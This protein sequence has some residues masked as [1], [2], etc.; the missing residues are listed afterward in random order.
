LIEE[1]MFTPEGAR[2]FGN[3]IVTPGEGKLLLWQRPESP[4]PLGR[5]FNPWSNPHWQ[6]SALR[7]ES[8]GWYLHLEDTTPTH[9]CEHD[10]ALDLVRYRVPRG[11]VTLRYR[12]TH[13]SAH[14]ETV[15]EVDDI[16]EN[17]PSEKARFVLVDG[18]LDIGHRD[19]QPRKAQFRSGIVPPGSQF[20]QL[21]VIGGG[22]PLKPDGQWQ[23]RVIDLNAAC[24]RSGRY[25]FHRALFMRLVGSLDIKSLRLHTC[26]IPVPKRTT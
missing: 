12:T 20:A 17:D 11:V 7:R 16:V 25:T 2:A 3:V 24:D 8:S 10:L 22:T 4:R 26:A 18:S 5:V 6:S 23:S 14:A 21:P 19:P 9:E 1:S 13:P 15:V